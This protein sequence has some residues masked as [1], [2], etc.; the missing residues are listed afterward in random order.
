MSGALDSK[1][2]KII[3]M[4]AK[5][6]YL[7]NAYPGLLF[8]NNCSW[9]AASDKFRLASCYARSP[10]LVLIVFSLPLPLLCTPFYFCKLTLNFAFL[11]LVLPH[12]KQTPVNL[13]VP[14]FSGPGPPVLNCVSGIML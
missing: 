9:M 10:L 6:L 1:P 11:W 4:Q 8:F 5:I 2:E 3:V 13:A 7:H 14:R 12:L